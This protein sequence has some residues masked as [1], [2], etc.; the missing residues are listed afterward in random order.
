MA[1]DGASKEV[2]QETRVLKLLVGYKDLGA[3]TA[4]RHPSGSQRCGCR[5]KNKR[6]AMVYRVQA[7]KSLNMEE[8]KDGKKDT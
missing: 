8:P 3:P 6:D 7:Y 1:R 2:T 5:R 4:L